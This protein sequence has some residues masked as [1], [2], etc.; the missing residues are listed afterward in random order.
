MKRVEEAFG[1]A[2]QNPKLF[3]RL[4]AGIKGEITRLNQTFDTL[5]FD[6]FF[7]DLFTGVIHNKNAGEKYWYAIESLVRHFGTLLSNEAW[8]HSRSS[9]IGPIYD[10]EEFRMYLFTT[11]PRIPSPDDFPVVFVVEH[12]NIELCEEKSLVIRDEDKRNELIDWLTSAK[13]NAEDLILFYY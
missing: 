5:Q 2:I 13:E 11:T 9:D 3:S 10:I 1:C 12:K 7:E 6:P 4:Q 8:S